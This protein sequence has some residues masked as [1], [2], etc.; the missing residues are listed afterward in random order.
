VIGNLIG[1]VLSSF[2]AGVL[3]ALW[4][5]R[6]ENF[7]LALF[8]IVMVGVI[9]GIW[10]TMMRVNIEKTKAR[11]DEVKKLEATLAK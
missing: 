5:F 7:T 11:I 3:F 8:A 2:A 10:G 4:L 9:S 1:L 6:R